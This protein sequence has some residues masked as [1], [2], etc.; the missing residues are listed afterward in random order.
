MGLRKEK[1]DRSGPLANAAR[2]YTAAEVEQLRTLLARNASWV[3]ISAIMRRPIEG[4]RTKA[5]ECK[6]RKP[7]PPRF[8]VEQISMLRERYPREG[9]VVLGKVLGIKRRNVN[10]WASKLGLVY[11]RQK[12]WHRTPAGMIQLRRETRAAT[13][14]EVAARHGLTRSQVSG[15]VWCAKQVMRRD[16]TDGE[17]RVGRAVPG[18]V[19]AGLGAGA[20]RDTDRLRAPG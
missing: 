9:A 5:T 19:A 10:W 12:D 17:A 15:A 4:L 11:V 13:V 14:R 1:K 6:F 3:E 2:P 18:H 20:R 16:R 8:S 7:K